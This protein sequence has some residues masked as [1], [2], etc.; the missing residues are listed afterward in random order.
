MTTPTKRE[1]AAQR[2]LESA[3]QRLGGGGG[4]GT[5]QHLREIF[6]RSFEF[7][8]LIAPDGLILEANQ[9][10]LSVF[11][12]TL[13][14]VVGSFLWDVPSWAAA[15]KLRA[16][17]RASVS[18]AARGVFVRHEIDVQVAGEAVTIDLSLKPIADAAG[19][20]VLVILE[21]RDISDRKRSELARQESEERFNRIVAIAADAIISIDEEQRITLFNQGA[22]QMFGYSALEV[23][24]QP[25]DLLLP[26]EL[27]TVH[28]REVER[29][30]T[31][32][33]AARRMGERRDLFG[34]RKNGEVFRADASISKVIINGKPV[35]T[36]VVRDVTERWAREEERTHLLAATDAARAEAER[37]KERIT[38]LAEISAGMSE[39]LDHDRA[40]HSLANTLVPAL[41]TCCFIDVVADGRVRRLE[42][43]HA[44][45]ELR[46]VVERLRNITLEWDRPFI[47]RRALRRGEPE[48]LPVVT[49]GWLR[50][51]A[52]NEEHLAVLLALGI[53][54][55]LIMPLVSGEE[56]IGAVSVLRDGSQ[57][58]FETD[59]LKFMLDVARRAALAIENTKLYD[60]S[61]RAT[62][63]RDQVLGMVSHDLRNPLSAIAMCLTSMRQASD[64]D[65]LSR[66]TLID[67]MSESVDLMNRLIDDLL[68]I[69]SIEAGKLSIAPASIDPVIAVARAI[70]FFEEPARAK[71]LKLITAVGDKL[72]AAH[73][74]G[75][76][77]VQ[78]LSNLL[79]NA[80]KFTAE[81]GTITVGADAD[82][83]EVAFFVRDSG[84]GIPEDELPQVFNQFWHRHRGSRVRGTGL[85]LAITKGIVEAHG[86][87]ISVDSAPGKGTTFRFTIPLEKAPAAPN[88]E[89]VAPVGVTR[90]T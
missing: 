89:T 29:F 47:S 68:D 67:T 59:D 63:Q 61:Q 70:L 76:R 14:N 35:F 81:G 18:A 3:L 33:T 21:G 48:L 19:L 12:S 5:D 39:S 72:P 8:A 40:L 44:S 28:R 2:V 80:I 41:A 74:D 90:P 57:P 85:G 88:R 54:S 4:S 53:R 84:I 75:D 22:E 46:D 82:D 38:L 6:H 45:T 32:S 86:G 42:A 34:R 62:A 51:V 50:S 30:A 36:A 66:G 77:L 55:A 49:E 24:S 83:A 60:R 64:M 16:D 87:Q 31:S 52:Q 73:A 9:R 71:H 17:V 25:I 26:A 37:A 65:S 11:G 79:N 20:V 1:A 78:A 7:I 56:T 58:A 43:L 23:I 69:F 15:A 13:E 27:A 10:A